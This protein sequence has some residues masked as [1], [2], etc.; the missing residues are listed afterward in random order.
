[1]RSASLRRRLALVTAVTRNQVLYRESLR[2]L[3]SAGA[4]IR[5]ALAKAGIDPAQIELLWPLTEAA[6]EL[7]ELGDTTEQ[8][9]AD[10]AFVAQDSCLATHQSETAKLAALA[11]QFVDNRRPALSDGWEE[12][13]AWALAQPGAG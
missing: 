2:D 3:A 4:T 9:R 10:A 13:Y 6:E 5:A 1:M 12:W 8:E 11:A 7:A